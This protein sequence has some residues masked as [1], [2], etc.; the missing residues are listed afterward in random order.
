VTQI[1][2]NKERNLNKKKEKLERLQ[3][4][5]EETSH[6]AGLQN[7]NLA[8]ITEPRRMALNHDEAI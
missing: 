7:F 1:T 8:W 4:V 2:W 3:E 6:K 5:P